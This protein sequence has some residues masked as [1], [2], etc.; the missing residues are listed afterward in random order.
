[1]PLMLKCKSCGTVFPSAIQVDQGSFA[2]THLE[3]NTEPCPNG[4][5]A[6]YD[7][8]DYFRIGE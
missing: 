4:H 8:G 6:S 1:M 7:K 5:S 3:N 2:S